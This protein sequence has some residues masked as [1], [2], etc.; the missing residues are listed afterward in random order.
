M[1]WQWQGFRSLLLR[2]YSWLSA[3]L[4][5]EK[6]ITSSYLRKEPRTKSQKNFKYQFPNKF[7][8]SRFK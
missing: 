7:Q 2:S 6:I 1:I 8:I 4:A 5:A 3:L